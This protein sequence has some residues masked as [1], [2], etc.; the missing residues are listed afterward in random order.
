MTCEE[1]V[2]QLLE[3]SRKELEETRQ[4]LKKSKEMEATLLA[5]LNILSDTL[6][7]ITKHIILE[8]YGKSRVISMKNVWE[9]CDAPDFI[10]LYEAFRDKFEEGVEEN[11]EQGE[12]CEPAES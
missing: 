11:G 5:R 10:A 7:V 9:N 3:D 1:Y 8:I 2:I 6:E 4:E 12:T